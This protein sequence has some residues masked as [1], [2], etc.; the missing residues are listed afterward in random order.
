MRKAKRE[1]DKG[2][3]I[4]HIVCISVIAL[5]LVFPMPSIFICRLTSSPK[6][7]TRVHIVSFVQQYIKKTVELQDLRM[8]CRV[9]KTREDEKEWGE[10]N[11]RKKGEKGGRKGG[12]EEWQEV[13]V[14]AEDI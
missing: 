14:E 13:E 8:H 3:K 12:S 2:V 7:S 4:S 11:G 1:F 5:W 6:Q 10:K 9:T